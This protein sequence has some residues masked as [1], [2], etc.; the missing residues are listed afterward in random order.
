MNILLVQPLGNLDQPSGFLRT[1][2]LEP[3]GLEYLAAVLESRGH[4]VRVE[5]GAIESA[6]FEYLIDNFQPD[7]VGYSVYSYALSRSLKLAKIAKDL[8]PDVTNIFGGYHPTAL[9]EVVTEAAVDYVVMGEGEKTLCDLVSAIERMKAVESIP[10]IA[11][12]G[13]NGVVKT[14]ARHRIRQLDVIPYPVREW[15][16]LQKTKQ[17][18]IAYPPPSEQVAVA[19]VTYSRGCPYDCYF[20]SSKNMWGKEVHW[21]DPVKVVDE[22]ESLYE[23]FG[24]NLVY[25]PDLTFNVNKKKSEELCNEMIKRNLPI[26]WWALFR[27]DNVDKDFLYHLKE[28]KCVKLS[29]GVESTDDRCI[30]KI[31]GNANYGWEKAIEVFDNADSIGFI[32][33]AFLMI[34]FPW[35]RPEDII[36]HKVRLTAS[37]IDEL[38]VT[39]ATPFPG[40]D[41]YEYCLK[42]QLVSSKNLSDFTTDIPVVF[43]SYISTSELIELRKYLVSGYYLSSSYQRRILDKIMKLPHLADSWIEY[44]EFLLSKET[45]IFSEIQNIKEF[46]EKL[47]K[48][49]KP[50]DKIHLRSHHSKKL[51][52]ALT[53][54]C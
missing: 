45:F 7:I 49:R 23:K 33:K 4:V 52:D 15:R 54:H 22:I 35:D 34:G 53:I 24:T 38:R 31:K 12:K 44:F 17:Y 41:Y 36:S 43:N 2:Y 37:A 28:A 40:T 3:L 6:Q 46:I 27:V 48:H 26:H 13:N 19:Q 51:A 47:S 32:V 25:F 16:Y 20:C 29:F 21:R 50:R 30:Q 42:E 9:P 8:L 39:F 5:Y 10:G 18:Q 11:Y 14:S 1:C